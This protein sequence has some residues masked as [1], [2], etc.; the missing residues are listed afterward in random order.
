MKKTILTLMIA[1]ATTAFAQHKI[2]TTGAMPM[3]PQKRMA[4]AA[5][6]PARV[7]GLSSIQRAVGYITNND[8]DSIT[9]RGA[10]VG[11]AGTYPVGAAITADMLAPYVGCKVVGIRVA[12]AQ[13]LGKTDLFL[14]P[15]GKD[16]DGITKSQRLYE[17]WNNVFF[18]GD[19]LWEISEGEEL[20]VGFNYQETEE[21]VEAKTGGLCTTGESK[22]ND[23]LIYNDFGQGQAWYGITKMGSLCVQLIVD[24]SSLPLKNLSLGYLDT[25]FR[26]K[27]ADDKI[28]L[29]TIAVNTGRETIDS[30]SINCQID[31]YPATTFNY[32]SNIREQGQ[33]HQQPILNMPEGIGIGAH[34]LTV[35]LATDGMTDNADASE[36]TTFYVYDDYMQRQKNYVEQYNSQELAMAATVNSI[37]DKA[38]S[39]NNQMALVNVYDENSSLALPETNYL[40]KLY[41][42]TLPSFTINRSYFPGEEYIAY[43]VN[44]YASQYAAIVPSIISD[45]MAQDLLLPAFA[46][47]EIKPQYDATTAT[48]NI[49]VTGE[50]AKGATEI[51]GQPAV[52]VLLTEDNVV[53]S[54]VTTNPLTHRQ[55]TEKNYKHNHVLRTFVTPVLGAPVEVSGNQY[56]AHFTTNITPEWNIDN[57]TL[58]AFITRQADKVDD[59]NVMQMDITNCNS[60]ALKGLDGIMQMENAEN[61]TPQYFTTDGKKANAEDMK[62]GIYIVK[63]GGKSHKVVI[64]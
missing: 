33:D 53:A 62:K 19:N 58:V 29:Y 50:L 44:Y 5:I 52:T 11:T 45:L 12:A 2:D 31:D 55:Q 40:H 39:N 34:K 14:Y 38:A 17:G 54:Q 23:F 42:Y 7:E 36:S 41:A 9:L 22:G 16:N 48:L 15:I 59:S 1:A 3:Q 6:P 30:Y 25:G 56:T 8:P 49:D 28:E 43:D 35:S 24:V 4:A 32:N 60:V 63:Q 47:V 10:M 51:L 64:K 18:N 61:D 46:T 20:L 27:L 26:Y 13:N 21:M 57:M 37:F